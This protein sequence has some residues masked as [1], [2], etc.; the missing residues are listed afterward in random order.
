MCETPGRRIWLTVVIFATAT[1]S[2]R[3][4]S[5]PVGNQAAEMK[6]RNLLVGV[7]KS[8][9]ASD[10]KSALERADLAFAESERLLPDSHPLRI[11]AAMRV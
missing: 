5:T 4:Q 7:Q 11:E 3:A 2:A 10:F 1:A 6:V 8:I 9:N